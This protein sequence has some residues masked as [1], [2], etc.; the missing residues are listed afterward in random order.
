MVIVEHLKHGFAQLVW[1]QASEA[2]AQTGTT[3]HHLVRHDW[4]VVANGCDNQRQSTC[5]GF[6]DS[7]V[8]AVTDNSVHVLEELELG[9]KLLN[10]EVRRHRTD[11]L[12]WPYQ[13]NL[14][15]HLGERSLHRL[16]KA[17]VTSTAHG[18]EGNQ[19]T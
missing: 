5:E 6:A 14:Q 1:L 17:N 11:E 19:N 8:P 12:W 7:V 9:Y 13:D 15:R 18:A 4:L 2:K 10:D 16:V 3:C